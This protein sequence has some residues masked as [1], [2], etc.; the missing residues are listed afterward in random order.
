MVG[1][2]PCI[3]SDDANYQENKKQQ[4]QKTNISSTYHYFLPW[5][6]KVTLIGSTCD[7]NIVLWEFVLLH[8]LHANHNICRHPIRVWK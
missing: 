3:C 8:P 7:Q 4:Q 2:A 6:L 1:E 5:E